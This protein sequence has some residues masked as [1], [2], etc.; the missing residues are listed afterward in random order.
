MKL[1][2]AL[3]YA[4]EGWQVFPLKANGKEPLTQNGFK[5]ATT[6]EATIRAWW[7]KYPD[8]N[9]GVRT[10]IDSGILVV[11]I[12]VKNGA[13][14]EESIKL[15]GGL[16]PTL[17]VNTPSGGWHHYYIVT[18][19]MRCRIGILPGVDIKA[20]GGYVVG[21]GS[22]IGGKDY[23]WVD[24]EAHLVAVPECILKLMA[25][26]ATTSPSILA[27]GQTIPE[28]SR[29]TE[30][31]SIAGT[32]R[33]RGIE[34]DVIADALR[35]VNAKKCSPPLPD[36]EIET[37]AQ[38]VSRYAPAPTAAGQEEDDR[39]ENMSDDALARAFSKKNS[40]DWRYVADWGYW[41]HWDGS[42]WRREKTL[43]AFDLARAICR[44]A[45]KECE[46][47]SMVV[48]VASSNTIAAIERIAKTDRCHAAVTEQWDVNPW[49]INTDSGVVDLK[50]GIL[51]PHE[52]SH[53]L[54]KK[55][56]AGVPATPEPPKR[57]LAFLNDITDGDVEL[58]AYLARLAGYCLTGVTSAHAL[59]FL[60]GTG[61]NGKSVFINTLAAVLGDYG[62]NAPMDT[63]M[64]TKMERH[65]TDLAG[66]RGARLVTAIE[67]EK[68]RRWAEAKIK[69]LTGGDKISARFM[70]GDFFEFVPQF[71]LLIAGNNK[72]LIRDVDNAIRR[73]LH[74]VPFTFTV[75]PEKQDPNLQEALLKERDGILQWAINGC[76]DW[77]KN[78]L[79]KAPCVEAATDEY[80]EAEDALG[81]WI[82]D[83]CQEDPV[84]EA[85]T[86]QLFDSWR[87][88]ADRS[89]EYAGTQRKFSDDLAKRGF[90]RVRSR[91]QRMFRGIGLNVRP[92]T[93]EY[94]D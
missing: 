88:W 3:A 74:L 24:P 28:G 10:G 14:G 61:A 72:P 4:A 68:G 27:P 62:T 73:R 22:T 19:P 32:M 7:A 63:F 45:A 86:E 51:T 17:A 58:Q 84:A 5:D 33:K 54:T 42:C 64:E 81:R 87:N 46:K 93:P 35:A 29:N 2:T 71:K 56:A 65:P 13:K 30:L 66:L 92:M 53:Y 21:P 34:A 76:L 94:H 69:S 23:T 85:S 8:A 59:F 37:I 44:E 78:G 25:E 82:Q 43:M 77:Q 67:V 90:E 47:D 40:A 38:S 91:S 26:A 9:I 50:T 11:D 36:S 6:D 55:T 41:I 75:P 52:R 1:D 57:W 49:I 79:K 15:F 12:D 80:M 31:T 83:E 39:P 70:R 60:Y 18:E 48:K 16:P 89:G 20:D